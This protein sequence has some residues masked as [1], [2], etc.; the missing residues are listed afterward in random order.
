MGF[1]YVASGSTTTVTG[2]VGLTAQVGGGNTP[3]SSSQV[4]NVLNTIDFIQYRATPLSGTDGQYFPAQADISGSLK[5][6][7]QFVPVAEDNVNGVIATHALPLAVQT[8]A[9]SVAFTST[10]TS[11][12]LIKSSSGVLRSISGRVDSTAPTANLYL[13]LFNSGSMP[14]EGV[15]VAAMLVAP[16]KVQ[17]TSGT[18]NTISIDFTN[19]GIF[20]SNG[21]I[22]ILSS[23]EFTKTI[24]G[25]FMSLTCEYK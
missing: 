25:S 19:N 23:T 1:T 12:L 15:G 10:L 13:Q 9:Y 7:E 8:Y 18:D 24:T 3:L 21:M 14:A 16:I 11:S 6:R 2:S 17:H 4:S 22:A 5:V 20:A